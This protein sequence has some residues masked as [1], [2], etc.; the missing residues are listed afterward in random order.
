MNI[1]LTGSG[2]IPYRWLK[3]TSPTGLNWWNSNTDS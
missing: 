3:S 2:E 1:M